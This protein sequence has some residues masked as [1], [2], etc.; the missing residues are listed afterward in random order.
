MYKVLPLDYSLDALEPYIGAETMEIHYNNIYKGYIDR[1]NR[2]LNSINYNYEYSLEELIKHIDEFPIQYRG[3]IL[4]NAGGVLNHNLYWMSMSPDRNNVPVGL[5]K[6][7][8]N[9]EYGSYDNFRKEFIEAASAVVG[10]GWTF[11]VINN[12]K[13]LEIINTPN[14]E[15]PYLYGLIPI[16]ALDLWEHAYFLKYKNKRNEYVLNFFEIVDFDKIN[17]LYEEKV[18]TI[19]SK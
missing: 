18:K 14:Q 3:E 1:L 15:T 4:Y 11:L 17:K 8:I 13:N 7:A 6:E 5:L 12:K 16:M 19:P 10:S 9:K 2:L